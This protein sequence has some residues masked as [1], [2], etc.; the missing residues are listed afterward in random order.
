MKKPLNKKQKINIVTIEEPKESIR[1]FGDMGFLPDFFYEDGDVKIPR[2]D[3]IY[4]FDDDC[5]D[6]VTEF[7]NQQWSELEKDENF[8]K[9]C[10]ERRINTDTP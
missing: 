2:E 1:T 10:I 7:V 8:S 3:V 5:Y 9:V 4:L 6:D